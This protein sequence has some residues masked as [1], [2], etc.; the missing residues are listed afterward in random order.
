M[1]AVG[2]KMLMSVKGFA[3]DLVHQSH[4][5]ISRISII[6]SSQSLCQES[7][8]LLSPVYRLGIC[9]LK[10]A[11]SGLLRLK[12]APRMQ[13]GMETRVPPSGA[14]LRTP[15]G[16]SLGSFPFSRR[17]CRLGSAGA[18]VR[19]CTRA[20]LSPFISGWTSAVPCRVAVTREVG[21]ERPGF[22][23]SCLWDGRWPFHPLTSPTQLTPISP[24]G[25]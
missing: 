11:S 20:D 12:Q 15:G 22:T 3:Y 17:A 4:D 2:I 7:R 5:T 14:G 13:C 16:C 19:V 23:W 24:Q 21:N 18:G 9:R 1:I 6:F 25:A 8:A 10:D